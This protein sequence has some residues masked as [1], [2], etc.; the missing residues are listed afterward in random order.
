MTGKAT[1]IFPGFQNSLGAVGTLPTV[2][3]MIRSRKYC[4]SCLFY[5]YGPVHIG[6][7]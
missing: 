4:I 7:R 5:V 2:T 1:L 6:H 3:L